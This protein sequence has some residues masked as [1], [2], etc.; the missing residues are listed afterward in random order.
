M[1]FLVSADASP[2]VSV[3][4]GIFYANAPRTMK[5][6]SP[7]ELGLRRI[8]HFGFFRPSMADALWRAHLLPEL[9]S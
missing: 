7:A 5:R 1:H 3:L 9:A 4:N 2:L 6:F 8:G